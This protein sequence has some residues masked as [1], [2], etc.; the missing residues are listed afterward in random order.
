R[1][2]RASRRSGRRGRGPFRPGRSVG[3]SPS[4]S[5]SLRPPPRRLY[6]ADP[7]SH[8]S[9][10]PKRVSQTSAPVRPLLETVPSKE[11]HHDQVEDDDPGDEKEPFE[12]HSPAP[13]TK[14]RVVPQI[15]EGGERLLFGRYPG[16]SRISGIGGTR[17]ASPIGGTGRA[18][19]A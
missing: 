10:P 11:V 3:P 14:L 16:R 9:P 1:G 5:L 19:A 7:S 8:I 17:A 18:G 13:A 2:R 12:G 6:R 15:A 4:P